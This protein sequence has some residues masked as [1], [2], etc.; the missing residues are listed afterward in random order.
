MIKSPVQLQPQSGFLPGYSVEATA[1][2]SPARK[3][4]LRLFAQAPRR[5]VCVRRPW[6]FSHEARRG[7]QGASRAVPGKSGLC[8]RGE[9]E[10]RLALQGG[11]GDFP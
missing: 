2:P 4:D 7:S 5:A 3:F 9:G 6:G 8:A 1:F 10:R 11:T